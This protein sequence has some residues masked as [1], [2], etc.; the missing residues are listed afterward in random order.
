MLEE[1]A[2]AR[3]GPGEGTAG[4]GP[5]T[6]AG[7]VA[8]VGRPNVGKSTLLNAFLGEKLSIVTPRAQTTREAVTGIYTDDQTQLIFVDTPGLLEPRYALQHSML[9]A[10]LDALR[11]A[12]V[13]L[14][15]LDPTR[16]DELP[17]EDALEAIAARR[18]ALLVVVN[19]T[20]AA[21]RETV[22]R[23]AAWAEREFGVPVFRVAAATGEG[24]P[25][26]RAAVIERMPASPFFYPADELAVQS[27]RFFV[28]ELIRETIFEEY[29]QEIPYSTAVR[30]EEFREAETPVFI[31]ATVYV[32]RESQ[33]KIVI[34][35]AGEGIRTLG[36][37]ARGKIEAFLG[38]TVYLDLWVKSLPN[39]RKKPA[40]L[41][42]LGYAIPRTDE[43]PH[44]S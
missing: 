2:Q 24:V 36:T 13:V 3:E 15:L 11:D 1:A 41:Q 9:D 43:R 18:D 8:L 42:Y 20:D 21:P 22:D 17:A 14:L 12:D 33:K 27:V 37:R 30:I 40:S 10:A 32:E 28:T 34:G 39:W 5:E 16:P 7:D 38:T 31:R 23:L 29:Q 4:T 35:R 44:N 26:L 25:A 19:K 6:R